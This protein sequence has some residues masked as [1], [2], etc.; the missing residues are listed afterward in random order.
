MSRIWAK[1]L[2]L[3]EYKGQKSTLGLKEQTTNVVSS[4]AGWD[5]SFGEGLHVLNPEH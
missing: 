5:K 3:V 4:P 1:S 2:K